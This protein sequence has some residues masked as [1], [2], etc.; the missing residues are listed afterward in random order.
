LSCARASEPFTTWRSPCARQSLGRRCPQPSRRLACSRRCDHPNMVTKTTSGSFLN[1]FYLNGS[2]RG[3]G[4]LLVKWTRDVACVCVHVSRACLRARAWMRGCVDAWMRGCVD[5]CCVVRCASCDN[6]RAAP[7][8]R[9]FDVAC[10]LR[11]RV[12]CVCTNVQHG[13]WL[14]AF[15]VFSVRAN[16]PSAAA[17]GA[18]SSRDT[19]RRAASHVAAPSAGSQCRPV[20]PH[21]HR[22]HSS[23]VTPPS[24][25]LP[26]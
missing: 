10:A 14:C 9:K 22:I 18:C 12:L 6:V 16:G 24:P 2:C 21:R 20:P 8:I 13:V 23:P 17:T 11:V 4:R 15:G 5:A 1:W 7:V 3:V 19:T 26:R 25:P